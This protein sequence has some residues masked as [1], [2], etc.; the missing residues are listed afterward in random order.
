MPEIIDRNLM[1]RT[2]RHIASRGSMETPK[3]EINTRVTTNKKILELLLEQKNINA[4]WTISNKGLAFIK[5]KRMCLP[6]QAEY[7]PYGVTYEI[8]DKFLKKLHSL[9]KNRPTPDY[10]IDHQPLLVESTGMRSHYIASEENLYDKD[11][12]MVGDFD[13]TSIG[14]NLCTKVNK[15][16][17]FDIDRRLID[18]LNLT[19]KKNNFPVECIYQD[20]FKPIPKALRG[21]YDV[22]VTDPPYAMGGMKKFIEFGIGL[23]KDGG[24]GYIAVPYHESISWTEKMLYEVNKII[25]QNGCAITDI[26]KNF[27]KYQTADGLRSSMIRIKKGSRAKNIE[28]KKMYSYKPFNINVP[29]VKHNNI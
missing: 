11:I 9:L 6:F 16:T 13:S 3:I 26:F 25:I 18:F 19:A 21:K 29:Y 8:N 17:V 5:D 23:L 28:L 15:M 4:D 12:A 7:T 22:F 20:L 24:V 27:H 2:L 1:V 10:E 14:I